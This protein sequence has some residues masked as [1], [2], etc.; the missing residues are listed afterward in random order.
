M[1]D[2]KSYS[3][4]RNCIVKPQ[5]KLGITGGIGE[6]KLQYAESSQFWEYLFFM[7]TG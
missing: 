7:L 5:F 6:V 3:N 4:K 1:P 2:G